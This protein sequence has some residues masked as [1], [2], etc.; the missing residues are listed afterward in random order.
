MI[1]AIDPGSAKCGLAVLNESGEI[2]MRTVVP[3]G[4]LPSRI[5]LLQPQTIVIW[6]RRFW[7]GDRQRI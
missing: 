6:Q 1:L 2:L 4:E 3:R 5:G 7:S